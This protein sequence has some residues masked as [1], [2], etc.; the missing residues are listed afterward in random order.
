[1]FRRMRYQY[2]SN[3][4]CVAQY[5]SLFLFSLSFAAIGAALDSKTGSCLQIYAHI[6]NYRF[7]TLS[8]IEVLDEKE[9]KSCIPFKK[10][11]INNYTLCFNANK[12][13]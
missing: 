12:K 10:L 8:Q 11:K 6:Q 3:I 9:T 2:S 1:M 4:Y 5:Y 13:K 7:L